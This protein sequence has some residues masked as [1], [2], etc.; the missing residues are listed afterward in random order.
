MFWQPTTLRDSITVTDSLVLSDDDSVEEMAEAE[1]QAESVAALRLECSTAQARILKLANALGKSD[2]RILEQ[3]AIHAKEKSDLQ[4]IIE[5][6]ETELDT[7]TVVS[8]EVNGEIDMFKRLLEEKET[9]VAQ[10]TSEKEKLAEV[11][12]QT[13]LEARV[14][15]KKELKPEIELEVRSQL[16]ESIKAQA[17]TELS[18]AREKAEAQAEE[19]EEVLAEL[20]RVQGLLQ[21]AERGLRESEEARAELEEKMRVLTEVQS[22]H[23][24]A[25]KTERAV[26][27]TESQ[28]RNQLGEPLQRESTQDTAQSSQVSSKRARQK[29]CYVLLWATVAFAHRMNASRLLRQ[30]RVK[31]AV[32]CTIA[33]VSNPLHRLWIQLLS[34][35]QPRVLV[36]KD[37]ADTTLDVETFLQVYAIYDPEAS[38]AGIRQGLKAMGLIQGRISEVVYREWMDIMFAGCN[39]DEVSCGCAILTDAVTLAKANYNQQG[40]LHH[41]PATSKGGSTRLPWHFYA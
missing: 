15:L 41:P 1:G 8:A 26:G 19:A 40:A 2:E 13:E 29:T 3:E 16:E 35:E 36:E 39:E 20:E 33:A 10:L 5:S 23:M 9:E 4:A 24:E 18:A 28:L 21:A 25:V 17:I 14:Q 32:A 7:F 30:W 11:Q 22:K 6:L 34:L 31:A 12:S 27:E 38:A 37:S